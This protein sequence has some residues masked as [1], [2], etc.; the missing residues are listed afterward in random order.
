[1]QHVVQHLHQGFGGIRLGDEMVDAQ[2]GGVLVS[3]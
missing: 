3:S 1:M 2:F